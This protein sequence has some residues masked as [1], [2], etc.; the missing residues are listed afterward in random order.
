MLN[1]ARPC[2]RIVEDEPGTRKLLAIL[3]DGCGFSSRSYESAEQF[4]AEDSL[5]E[6]GC[7]LVDLELSGLSGTDLVRWISQH[8]SP[9]PTIVVTGYGSAQSAVQCLKSGAV[10][11]LEKPIDSARLLELVRSAV[12][13]DARL[14]LSRQHVAELSLRVQTLSPRE[15]QVMLCVCRGLSTKEIA[16]EL[17]IAAKTVEHHRAQVMS[18]MEAGSIAELVKAVVDLGL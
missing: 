17:G 1:Y 10:D 8:P 12:E 18:K 9:L 16:G 11:F 13:L 7:V 4:M 14:R 15:K 6:P 3:I 5:S 2:I